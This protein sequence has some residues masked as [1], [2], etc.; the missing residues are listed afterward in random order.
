MQFSE[1]WLRSQVNPQLDSDALTHLLTMAGLEVEESAPA[2]PAFSGVVVARIIA[3]EAHPDADKLRLTRVDTGDAEL[4][5]IVCGASNVRQGLKVPV[6]VVG[7]VL[8]GDFKIKK[9]KLRGQ[10]S[11]GMLCSA[12][13][14][15]LAE[16]S[17]GL[18]ELPDNAPIGEDVRVYLDLDDVSIDIDLTPLAGKSIAFILTVSANGD[19]DEDA[20]FWLM[21]HIRRK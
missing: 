20:A 18:L 21:P 1:T 11:H 19:A 13:E 4:L 17:D 15:G 8:P 16:N 2:A 3:L 12:K 9:A 10:P 6:A 14:L 7:A 5:D